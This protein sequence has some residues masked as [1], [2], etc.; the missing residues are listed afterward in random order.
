MESLLEIN[1]I[2]WSTDIE[3]SRKYAQIFTAGQPDDKGVFTNSTSEYILKTYVR[4]PTYP[5]TQAPSSITD[6]V[7]V[8][9]EEDSEMEQAKSY[10]DSR[11]GIPMKVC[12]TTKFGQFD[13]LE[14]KNVNPSELENERNTIIKEA[15]AF[16]K[17]LVNVFKKFDLNGNGLISTDE[18]ISC[19]K[20]LG[21][22]LNQD[23][24]QMI[25]DTLDKDHKGNIDFNGFKKWWV[26]GKTDFANFRRIVKAEMAVNKLIKLSSQNFNNY[27][28]NLN[29]N[30]NNVAQNEVQQ[31]ISLNMHPVKS[32]DNGIGIYM[33]MCSGPDAK[34]IFDSKNEQVR[35][36]PVF[37]SLTI[38]MENN[39]IASQ[40]A[41][42]INQMVAPM[43]ESVPQIQP[44]LQMGLR[45]TIRADQNKL[46]AEVYVEAM[47]A[48]I[49]INQCNQFNQVNVKAG[50]EG[51]LHLFTNA[52]FNDILVEKDAWKCLEKAI[53]LKMNFSAKAYNLRGAVDT[54]C[55]AL[56]DQ[57]NQGAVSSKFK[58]AVMATRFSG[59][60]R[61]FNLDFKFDPS[62]ILDMI[63]LK[64]EKEHVSEEGYS[65]LNFQEFKEKIKGVDNKVEERFLEFVDKMDEAISQIQEMKESIPPEIMEIVKAINMEKIEMQMGFNTEA[66]RLFSKITL[67]LPEL[68]T[69]RNNILN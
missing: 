21:H 57:I 17:T 53:N 12:L 31:S 59:V 62:L 24:A 52:N 55:N 69:V 46:V 33:D 64:L 23:D 41:E 56:E 49:M 7:F 9:V 65:N 18:L 1:T 40:T 27:L 66:S 45:Y 3:N 50:G 47:L 4:C 22:D 5:N 19:S 37:V 8:C 32:F 42:M 39:E 30:S 54:V 36:S 29:E 28:T 11:R 63:V 20:E 48:E 13:D 6:I 38:E 68:N 51:S 2:V 60:L 58:A 67:N 14:C 34:E 16:E 26:T 44:V 61:S 35:N 15:V 43:L 10:L 25:T